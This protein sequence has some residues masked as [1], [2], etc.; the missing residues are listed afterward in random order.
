MAEHGDEKGAGAR[1]RV[2]VWDGAPTTWRS[3]KREVTWWISSLDLESTKRYN[4]AARWL[5]RKSGIVRQ[6]GEEFDPSELAYKPAVEGA[7][8]A[9]GDEVELEPA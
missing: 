2:P 9:T 5:L 4:L 1:A 8:P 6:R 7:D 3:F